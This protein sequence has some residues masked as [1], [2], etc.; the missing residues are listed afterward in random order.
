MYAS[1]EKKILGKNFTNNFF[2]KASLWSYMDKKDYRRHITFKWDNK[3][4]K[5]FFTFPMNNIDYNYVVYFD[6]HD[7]ASEYIKFI[8]N[9]Y[10]E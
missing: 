10:L 7:D 3:K 8:I 9:D 6:T 5:Y 1:S 2:E 4:K